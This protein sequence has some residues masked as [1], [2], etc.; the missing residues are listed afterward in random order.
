M[1]TE[2]PDDW[3]H[4]YVARVRVCLDDRLVSDGEFRGWMTEILED[5]ADFAEAQYPVDPAVKADAERLAQ[6]MQQY[7]FHDGP[8]PEADEAV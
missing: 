5:L 6:A 3:L 7:I 1:I 4:Y 8:E 2:R